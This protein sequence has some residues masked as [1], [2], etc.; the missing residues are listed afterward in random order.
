MLSVEKFNK[1]IQEILSDVQDNI[2]KWYPIKIE[3]KTDGTKV[4]NVDIEINRIIC[5]KFKGCHIISEENSENS[6]KFPAIVVDPVDGTKELI[7]GNKQWTIS[8]AYIADMEHWNNS[9][10]AILNVHD[11]EFNNIAIDRNDI[12]VSRS[13]I[14]KGLYNKMPGQYNAIG[15]IAYKLKLLSLGKGKAVITKRPKS[16]WDIAAGTILAHKMGINFYE[17]GVQISSFEKIRYTSPMIW[18]NPQ[19]LSSLEQLL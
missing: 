2:N 10:A 17:N 4:T 1:S 5:E 7:K 12:L 19:D 11:L 6:L 15:S 8:I 9:Y 16:L 18:C 14:E 3:N 13:E